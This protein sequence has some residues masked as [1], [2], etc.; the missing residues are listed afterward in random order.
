MLKGLAVWDKARQPI[1]LNSQEVI[2]INEAPVRKCSSQIRVQGLQ[3]P[4][5]FFQMVSRL[6]LPILMLII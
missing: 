2:S 1:W 6:S 5:R 4:R 3:C